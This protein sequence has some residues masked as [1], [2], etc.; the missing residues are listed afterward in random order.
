[1]SEHERSEAGS[2]QARERRAT[3]PMSSN[4]G[5]R[6][7]PLLQGMR[8]YQWV[9]NVACLA[10]LVFSGRLLQPEMQLRALLA[11]LG[12]SAASS[13]VYLVNDFFDRQR[14]LLNPRTAGRPLASGRLPVGLAAFAAAV[15][16]TVSIAIAAYLGEACVATLACYFVLNIAYSLRLKQVVIADV[17]CIALG[18]VARVLFGV[19]A[20]QVRPT[21]WI[22]LCMFSLALFLGFGKRRGE[23]DAMHEGAARARP[24]L[25][26]YTTRF[27][28]FAMGLAATSTVT[29]YALY[30]IA[31]HHDP[32]MIATI[33]PVVYCVLRYAHQVLVEGRGQSPERLLYTDKMLWI[34]IIAWIALSIFVLYGK[35]KFVEFA[36]MFTA[37]CLT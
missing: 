5:T 9:K 31:P 27:L 21:P 3:K 34:G 28:D 37:E 36:G 23:I 35:P 18:F 15:L 30:C 19:Y 33:F 29:T 20:V 4:G 12:F 22:V 26:R 16:I 11:M 7:L 8:P 2:M 17:I 32:N 24:V 14:D 13:A 10:G 6:L 1:M 25:A